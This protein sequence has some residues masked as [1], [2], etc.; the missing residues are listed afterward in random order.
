MELRS[1]PAR[2][3][4]PAKVA[5]ADEFVSVY[6]NMRNV[7]SRRP[8]KVGEATMVQNSRSSGAQSIAALRLGRRDG[9]DLVYAGASRGWCEAGRE[10]AHL[11]HGYS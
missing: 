9:A 8:A 5:A 1:M 2:S 7:C 10:I 6:R 11:G 4:A 3:A